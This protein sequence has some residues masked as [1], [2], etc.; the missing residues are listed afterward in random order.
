MTSY[1]HDAVTEDQ[2]LPIAR[3]KNHPVRI[4]SLV[5]FWILGLCNNYGYVVMLSAASDIIKRN[6]GNETES[7]T[8][9]ERNCNTISTGAILLADIIP[10]LAIKVI[11]P[12]FPLCI[13]YRMVLILLLSASGFVLVAEATKIWLAIFGVVNIALSSGLG[14]ATLLSYMGLYKSTDVISNWS[15]GTGGAGFFGSLTYMLLTILFSEEN[16]AKPLYIFLIVP[17]LMGFS[18]WVLLDKPVYIKEQVADGQSQET[19][20]LPSSSSSLQEMSVLQHFMINLKSIPPLFK[21]MIPFG[22]VYLFEYFINQGMF[23]L[24]QFNGFIIAERDQYVIYQLAYQIGVFISRSSI[25]L[26]EI[27]NIWLLAV[28]QGINVIIFTTDAIYSYVPNIYITLVLILYEGF[29]GGAAYVNTFNRITHEVSLEK[30]EFSM[31][32]TSLG[33]AAGISL[34]GYLAIPSHNAICSLPKY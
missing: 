22:L 24:I 4:K 3:N 19:F 14:E 28:L 30:R 20:G 33:D 29:L 7:P 23:E 11:A 13:H 9:P 15:S 1:Q 21:Y 2:Q 16:R 31:S 12:F 34:A 26:I 32:I 27:R 6:F 8:T 25:K 18:F 5:A 17:C 10:S